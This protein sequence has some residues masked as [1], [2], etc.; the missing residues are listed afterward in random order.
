MGPVVKTK[1]I[2]KQDTV[3]HDCLI[4]FPTSKTAGILARL[5]ALS[6]EREHAG[7]QRRRD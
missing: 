7:P 6:A 4:S 3:F 2:L 1:V 5:G